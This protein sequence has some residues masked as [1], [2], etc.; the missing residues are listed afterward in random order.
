MAGI[1]SKSFE[2]PDETR[3]PDK[4]T[5]EVVE[6]GGAKAARF[7]MEPGWRWDECI[8]PAAGTDACQA[9]HLGVA[10]SGVLHVSHDD[11]TELDLTAGNAY[12]IDPGHNAWVVGDE[13]FVAYEF[14][15]MTAET[16]AR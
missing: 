16:F 1:A 8:K 3:R 15:S 4:T 10:V 9:R 6:L 13:P 12:L 5:V 14:E 7:T 11:G 2:T